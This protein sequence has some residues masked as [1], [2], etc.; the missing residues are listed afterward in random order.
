MP[1]IVNVQGMS[2]LSN[3]LKRLPLLIAK[4]ALNGP[5]LTAAQSIRDLARVKAP[6]DTGRLRR[7]IVVKRISGPPEKAQYIIAVKH[8][9]SYMA[10]GKGKRNDDA[11]YWTFIEF[12]TATQPKRPFLRPS[13]EEMKRTCLDQIVAGIRLNIEDVALETSW[14]IGGNPAFSRSYDPG[15]RL[16]R[17][18]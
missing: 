10:V 18:V 11:Y 1:E 14:H 17:V 4:K 13:F 8:G 16:G 3:A 5:V 12:G 2:Q 7:A 9:I 15:Q 6:M